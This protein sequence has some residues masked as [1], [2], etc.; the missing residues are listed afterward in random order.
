MT[1]SEQLWKELFEQV[2]DY[3][4]LMKF[5]FKLN[6]LHLQKSQMS[7]TCEPA[8]LGSRAT[9]SGAGQSSMYA[10][11]AK[12]HKAVKSSAL[13]MSFFQ[14]HAETPPLNT[15]E[16]EI[17][18][19]STVRSPLLFIIH[20]LNKPE[21]NGNERQSSLPDNSLKSPQPAAV[22]TEQVHQTVPTKLIQPA[23]P[24]RHINLVEFLDPTAD[25]EDEFARPPVG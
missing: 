4:L 15:P 14:P 23:M 16:I 1:K 11:Q 7:V 10:K 21:P 20:P 9:Y 5:L 17:E 12:M 25:D 3:N 24:S 13:I 6:Y 22:Q 19:T 8:K 18:P 2:C